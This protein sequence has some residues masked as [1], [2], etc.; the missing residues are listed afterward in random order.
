MKTAALMQLLSLAVTSLAPSSTRNITSFVALSPPRSPS[1]EKQVH[2]ANYNSF[3]IEFAFMVDYAGNDSYVYPS[4]S[5]TTHHLP[6][7]GVTLT[8]FR[9]PNT[10]SQ[11]VIQNLID[12]T[13]KAPIF[14]IGGSTQSSAVYYPDQVEAIIDPFDS[15]SSTQPAHSYIGP[16]FMQ[17][18]HQ[19]P[20][21]SQYIYG[22]DLF[23]VTH[24]SPK[25]FI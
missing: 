14:R 11:Q 21:D 1:P 20:G 6:V 19:F 25:I 8:V 13:G 7:L 5:S 24:F 9:Q 22:M 4:L 15:I 16:A 23:T 17:S 10:F 12:I 18:F 2:D 3:S